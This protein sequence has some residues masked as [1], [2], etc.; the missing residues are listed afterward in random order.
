MKFHN[1]YMTCARLCIIMYYILCIDLLYILTLFYFIMYGCV[2][3][4]CVCLS[5]L[6]LQCIVVFVPDICISESV[7]CEEVNVKM[8][9]VPI[10][11]STPRGRCQVWLAPRIVAHLSGRHRPCAWC[12]FLAR[13]R[14]FV[15]RKG[16][17]HSPVTRPVCVTL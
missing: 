16:V 15:R 12:L 10:H 8:Y 5:V 2:Y 14:I 9:K 7:Y 1:Q 6:C 11:S 4:V 17:P 3:T 13:R